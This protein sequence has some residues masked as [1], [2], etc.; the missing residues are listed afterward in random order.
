M[1]TEKTRFSL[2]FHAVPAKLVTTK[3]FQVRTK[4]RVA[5]V[6]YLASLEQSQLVGDAAAA[7]LLAQELTFL[8]TIKSGWGPT[9]TEIDSCAKNLVDGYLAHAD[10]LA[11]AGFPA[12]TKAALES[13]KDFEFGL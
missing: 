7:G 5:V 11:A 12:P 10:A 13:L 4:L 1:R 3:G 9:A 8:V 6:S 2:A